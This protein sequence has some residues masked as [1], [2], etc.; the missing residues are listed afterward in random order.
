MGFFDKIL[1][2][3]GFEDDNETEKVVKV[4]KEEPSKK[5]QNEYIL[6]NT[7][8]LKKSNIV[9]FSPKTQDEIFNIIEFLKNNAS[10]RIDFA[11]FPEP[12][13]YRAMDFIQGACYALGLTP[14]FESNKVFL[15][16]Q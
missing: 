9:E 2:G 5:I 3:L 13:I 10:V 14:K 1:Q 6:N 11:N 4:K 15:I 8:T 16:E 7:N 12:D